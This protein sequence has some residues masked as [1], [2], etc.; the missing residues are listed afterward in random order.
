M[1][2]ITNTLN[3]NKGIGIYK[4]NLNFVFYSS[5]VNLNLI[6]IYLYF[7]QMYADTICG[8]RDGGGGTQR[9][10][11]T[12]TDASNPD[13]DLRIDRRRYNV[14]K[15]S[16]APIGGDVFPSRRVAIALR[17]IPERENR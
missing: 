16:R 12:R 13:D 7:L 6:F 5:D 8:T 15:R 9:R 3:T 17:S 4:L 10:R 2:I 1:N 11:R 14:V